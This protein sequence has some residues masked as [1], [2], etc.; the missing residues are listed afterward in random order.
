[1]IYLPKRALF[2]HIPRTAGNS[3][4]NAIASSCAGNNYDIL[5]GTVANRFKDDWTAIF[6]THARACKLKP[7][8]DDW[9]DIFKFAIYRDEKERLESI[10]RLVERDIKQ[11]TYENKVCD[12]VWKKIL[13]NNIER[14]NFYK[15]ISKQDLNF[16]IKS[17]NGDDLGVEIFEYDNLSDDWGRICNKCG[18]EPCELKHLNSSR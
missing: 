10:K 9:D 11:R 8:I 15:T 4:T 17:E 16:Y 14:N 2:I 1:M 7:Y 3:I 6:Q 5:I 12:K 13:T 18:I